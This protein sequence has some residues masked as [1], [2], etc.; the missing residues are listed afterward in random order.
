VT[1]T[2]DFGFLE[3]DRTPN[4]TPHGAHA[5][6]PGFIIEQY[7]TDSWYVEPRP[8]R[9]PRDG[10]GAQRRNH[11]RAKNWE[12]GPNSK[13][14]ENIRPVYLGQLW[15]GPI[16]FRPGGTGPHADGKGSSRNEERASQTRL[17]YYAEQNHYAG[18]G[19]RDGRSTRP[20]A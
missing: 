18:A 20:S 16:R 2:E 7:L 19:A 5:I 6:A 3:R 11:V 14:M 10:S 1:L 12:E 4:N 13:W 15:G 9:G 17:G 8:W